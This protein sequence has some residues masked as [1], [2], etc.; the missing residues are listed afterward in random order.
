MSTDY[1]RDVTVWLVAGDRSEYDEIRD[2]AGAVVDLIGVRREYRT[3]LVGRYGRETANGSVFSIRQHGHGR[4][5]GSAGGGGYDRQG[6]AL[7]DA[8]H[9]LYGVP[10]IDGA[11]GETSVI[12]HARRFGVAVYTL[13]G[14]L[15]AVPT[16]AREMA[17]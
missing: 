9:V 16:V 6:S 1:L 10:Q 12:E 17:N 2:S 4:V 14:A 3:V 5:V 11:V 13:S 15:Y 7:A 8:L